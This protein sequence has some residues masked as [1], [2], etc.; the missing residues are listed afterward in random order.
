MNIQVTRDVEGYQVNPDDWDE[1][2]AIELAKEEGIQI[3]DTFWSVMKFMRTYLYEHNIA[4]D[5]R[6]LI[7][8][9]ATENQLR[10]KKRRK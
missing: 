9:L 2:I 3:N 6:H 10:K 7:T 4:P 8:H 1:S 5:V